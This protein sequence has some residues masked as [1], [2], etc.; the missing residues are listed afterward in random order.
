[1]RSDLWLGM[2]VV[3]AVGLNGGSG[4]TCFVTQGCSASGLGAF[5]LL[6]L[7]LLARTHR[8]APGVR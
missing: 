6:A 5:V 3:V 7:A 1:M 4:T 2:S 8:S